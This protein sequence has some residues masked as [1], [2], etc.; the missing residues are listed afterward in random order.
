MIIPQFFLNLT[1]PFKMMNYF[2]AVEDKIIENQEN[3]E[4]AKLNEKID[5]II[6]EDNNGIEGVL[7]V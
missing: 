6:N 2:K 1:L 5:I 4:K 7:K 3:Q